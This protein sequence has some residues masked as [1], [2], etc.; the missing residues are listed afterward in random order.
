MDDSGTLYFVADEMLGT[1]ARRLRLLG[2][3]TVYR[4][5]P[6][7]SELRYLVCSQD[8]ILLTRDRNL[9]DSLHSSAWLV[10]GSDVREEFQSIA[11]QLSALSPRLDPLS[12]CLDCNEKLLAIDPVQAQGRVPPYIL[13]SKATFSLCPSCDKVFWDG[14]HSQR[15]G[16][17]VEWMEEI[18]KGE[19]RLD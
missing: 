8:R 11:A 10:S 19:G 4:A 17:E 2:I 7:E 14:T 18:L 5:K 12:R 9:F 16:E 1:L 3:D 6:D 15:M 13:Q